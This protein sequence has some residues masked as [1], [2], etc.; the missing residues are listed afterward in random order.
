MTYRAT[1]AVALLLSLVGLTVPTVVRGQSPSP[2]VTAAWLAERMADPNLVLWHVGTPAGY[3]TAH[4]PGARLVSMNDVSAASAEGALAREM[5]TVDVLQRQLQDLG[6]SDDSTVVVYF[7]EDRVSH[8]TRILFTLDYAGLGARSFLLDGGMPAWVEAGHPVTTEVPTP[9]TGRLSALTPHPIVVDAATVTAKLGQNGVS[10][11]DG[12][13]AVFYDGV[14][15]ADNK[16]GHIAGALSVP[17]TSV[18]DDHNRLLSNEK[19]TALF[20]EAGVK[21]GDTVIGY[22]HIGQQA[23][24]MLFAARL[25]GHPVLLYDG[26]F[27]DWARRNL[28]VTTEKGRK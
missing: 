9:K 18:V 26:S 14:Q 16:T 4:L 8:A 7:G 13:A 21:A 23:T 27:Q 6:I 22:C 12:R 17:F 5:P 1:T 25:L 28:P 19:L 15:P 11:V 3:E 24:A 2:L 20:E 10:V